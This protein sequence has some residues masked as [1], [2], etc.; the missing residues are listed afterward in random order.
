M[1][2]RRNDLRDKFKVIPCKDKNTVIESIATSTLKSENAKLSNEL[3]LKERVQEMKEKKGNPYK[4]GNTWTFFY[5]IKDK[6]G[7]RKQY[8]K[9]GY[10]TQ[11]EAEKA[12]KE[13]EAQ[14]L[15][16]TFVE[17]KRITIK[18]YL[19]NWYKKDCEPRLATN[20]L[21]GYRT[22]IYNHIIPEIGHIQL[23][24]IGRSDVK[25]LYIK[26]QNKGLSATSI[27]YVHRT[28][29]KALKE[30]VLDDVILK[31]PCDSIELP[32]QKKYNASTLNAEQ[33]KVL[34]EAIKGTSI[35]LPVLLAASLGLRK[36]ECLGLMFKDFDFKKNTV[37]IQRQLNHA[38]DKSVARFE[39]CNLKTEGSDR[40]LNVPDTIVTMIKRQE[41]ILKLRQGNKF[42]D[43]SLVCCNDDDSYMN[44]DYINRQLNKIIGLYNLPKIRFH[45]LRHSFASISLELD[46]PISV[47][48]KSLGH[49]KISTTMDIYIDVL[50]R[51]EE[52]AKKI[53]NALFA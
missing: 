39:L 42:S 32:K 27:K 6:H 30:A 1:D 3:V 5:Y 10:K 47:I 28:L 16:G 36:G 41:K 7:K 13:V 25:D 14:I 15:M 18:D 44:P 4:R 24:N 17:P 21:T 9:G 37:H 43:S 46:I 23:Q 34:F 2:K 22:N 48:S 52:L 12:L 51:K 8:Q 45:D 33:V 31:N 19:D 53:Q 40:F 11:K 38:K 50:E 29:S 26:L 20:T 49:S 35:E